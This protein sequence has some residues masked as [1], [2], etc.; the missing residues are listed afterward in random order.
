MNNVTYTEFIQNILNTRGRFACGNEYHEQHHIIPR[1]LGGTDEEDNLIDL[2]AREH[3]IAHKMLAEE[4]PD[5]KKLILAW[6]IM[7]NVKTKKQQRYEVTPEEYEEARIAYSQIMIGEN[8]PSKSETTRRKKSEAIKG[9]KNHNYGKPR[10]ESTRK[11]ISEA[12]KGKIVSEET[13][14]R[15]SASKTG[16]NNPSYGKHR[17]DECRKKMSESA[18]ARRTEE[19]R[20]KHQ[21][22]NN[23][24]AKKIIRLSDKMIYGCIK[25]A[26]DENHVS[27][28]IMRKYCKQHNNFM[29]YDEYLTQQN[30]SNMENKIN[31]QESCI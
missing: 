10:S 18:K 1:C 14:K 21:G 23:P 25:Q 24:S 29:Y 30:D 31:E 22:A 9:E 2:F 11:K 19:W 4:N 17:S 12:H 16:K 15:I 5:N 7:T 3:F 27:Y 8:N 28:S 20:K 13:C 6:H 26:A